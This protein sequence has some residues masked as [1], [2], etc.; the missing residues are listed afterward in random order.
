MIVHLIQQ[1]I[2][3]LREIDSFPQASNDF[4]TVLCMIETYFEV[5]FIVVLILLTIFIRKA[6]KWMI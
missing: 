3:W 5:S 1:Y 2:I 4:F 6:K